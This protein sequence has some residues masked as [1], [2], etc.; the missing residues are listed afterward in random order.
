MFVH[1]KRVN[2]SHYC[3]P[4][5][6]S[7]ISHKVKEKVEVRLPLCTA[8]RADREVEEQLLSFLPL[9]KNESGHTHDSGTR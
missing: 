8:K 6:L 7:Y 5:G 9:E 2:A 1:T 3:W 4:D